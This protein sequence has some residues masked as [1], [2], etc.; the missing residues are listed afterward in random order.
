MDLVH[1]STAPAIRAVHASRARGLLARPVRRAALQLHHHAADLVPDRRL[2]AGHAVSRHAVG[3]CGFRAFL[4]WGPGGAGVR[5]GRVRFVRALQPLH[6]RWFAVGGAGAGGV[7]GCC[8]GCGDGLA[9]R[10]VGACEGTHCE[11]CLGVEL[12]GVGLGQCACRG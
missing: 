12:V 9:V 6:E 5:F 3:A 7:R 11:W 10:V 4:A 1:A 8:C 2:P